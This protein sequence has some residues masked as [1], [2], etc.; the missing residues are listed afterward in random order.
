MNSNFENYTTGRYLVDLSG[1]ELAD[2][3]VMLVQVQFLKNTEIS[4]NGVAAKEW[5]DNATAE[6]IENVDEY[7]EFVSSVIG[8]LTWLRDHEG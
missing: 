5:L 4:T 1:R 8:D 7:I 2:I 3:L 6:D